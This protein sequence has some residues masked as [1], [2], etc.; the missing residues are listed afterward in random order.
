MV[1]YSDWCSR[2]VRFG[3]RALGRPVCSCL[4]AC[5]RTHPPI[6]RPAVRPGPDSPAAQRPS[7]SVERCRRGHPLSGYSRRRLPG[8]IMLLARSFPTPIDTI[9]FERRPHT[10]SA[11]WYGW[12]GRPSSSLG[13]TLQHRSIDSHCPPGR[14]THQRSSL[15][16]VAGL[17]CTHNYGSIRDQPG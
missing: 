13:G 3:S 4:C 1:V 14:P 12:L 8:A 10:R 9:V 11:H 5:A 17:R 16:W 7:D 6:E 2:A 15:G